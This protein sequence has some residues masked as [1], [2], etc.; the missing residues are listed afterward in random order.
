[1]SEETAKIVDAEIKSLVMGGYEGAKKLL[2]E[3]K[4]D[5][6]KL[7]EALI[8]YETLTGEEIKDVLAG[9]TIA[10][11]KDAPVAEERKTRA[12]IPEL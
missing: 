7:S 3:H 10:K 8:E 5:W 4:D 11:G 12:S 6:E 1:M 2:S 9:K